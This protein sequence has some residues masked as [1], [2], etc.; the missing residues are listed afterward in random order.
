MGQ[1]IMS[2]SKEQHSQRNGPTEIFI[3]SKGHLQKSKDRPSEFRSVLGP[4]EE[5][6]APEAEPT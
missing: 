1:R 2:T 5:I 6:A 3:F 4:L